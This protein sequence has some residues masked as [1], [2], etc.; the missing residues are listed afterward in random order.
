MQNMKH[1]SYIEELHFICETINMLFAKY[2]YGQQVNHLSVENKGSFDLVT[3]A[4][5]E[6]EDAFIKRIH[7]AY[8]TD[9]ILSE[10]FHSSEIIHGRTWTIDPIDGTCNMANGI[11]QYGIQ[12]C[13]IDKG[14]R[15][16][17]AIRTCTGELF[18]A[19]KGGGAFYN[20]TRIYSEPRELKKCVASF[21]DF[22]H[23]SKERSDDTLQAINA[24]KDSIM[25]V[26][27]FGAACLD[28]AY[29]AA[30]RTDLVFM[31]T[32]NPWDIYPGILLC[33][34]AGCHVYGMDGKPYTD[35]SL[36]VIATNNDRLAELVIGKRV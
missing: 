12:V 30:G 27:L 13:L 22:P 14:E 35:S 16:C 34:E 23:S 24:V 5:M 2:E 11:P 15:V 21:G 1:K 19:M 17:S 18:T 10:E 29:L 28:Y 31:Y 20:G 25:K 9:T 33:E 26:R 32:Q 8:P 3:S 6:I 7:E 4:D 36:G